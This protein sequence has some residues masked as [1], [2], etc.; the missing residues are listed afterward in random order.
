MKSEKEIEKIEE[1]NHLESVLSVMTGFIEKHPKMNYIE[2]DYYTVHDLTLF[3]I[4]P[5]FDFTTL[6]FTSQK[7]TASLKAVKRIFSK[8]IVVL[9]DEDDVLPVETV[10]IINQDTMLH[11]ASHSENVSSIT[12]D[13]V[14]P[15]KLLTRVYEDDYGI[16]ENLI[17]GNYIDEVIKYSKKNIR[18]LKDLIYANEIMEF[19]LLER[20]NHLDYFLA[21]GKLHTGYIRDFEKYYK[22]S[23]DLY[24]ELSAILNTIQPRLKRPVYAKNKNRNRHLKLK[25]TNIFLMQKDYHQIYVAYKYMDNHN[26]TQKEI[27]ENIDYDA[28][29][30]N[31]FSFMQILI[32]F[33]L[34]HFNFEMDPSIKMNMKTID[35]TFSFKKWTVRVLNI[36]NKGILL[37]ISKDKH[38]SIMLCPSILMENEKVDT[39]FAKRYGVDECLVCN[40]FETDYLKRDTIYISMEN[41]ESFRRIQQIILRG[42]VYS[43]KERCDCPFCHGQ[44]SYNIKGKYYECQTCGTQIKEKICPTTKKKF[45][46]TDIANLK[47]RE[48]KSSD[49]SEDDQWLFN[50]KVEALMYFRNITKINSKSE[51]VCPKCLEVHDK[52]QSGI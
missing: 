43:D 3:S 21:L 50:R 29:Y 34:G 7:I 35:A 48:V 41:I 19:N 36:E 30:K 15:R 44:L 49:F 2:F 8:P 38:Y 42:M 47:K 31:Y 20:V 12:K 23:K 33:A 6:K 24:N 45:F 1:Y 4:E 46:Y 16:Y 14:R 39:S 22:I 51:I 25:K 5:D 37:N 17:F 11:L 13:G 26:L 52:R 27:D 32:V 10:R 28:L 40:P 9:N 18:S